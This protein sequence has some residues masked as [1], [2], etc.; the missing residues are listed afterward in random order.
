MKK[1]IYILSVIL[2]P[3]LVYFLRPETP[4]PFPPNK[5]VLICGASSGIGKEIALQLAESHTNL[6]IV[7]RSEEKLLQVK[8]EALKRGA[9]S[10]HILSYDFS[11]AAESGTVIDKVIK[12]FGT[13]DYLILNHAAMPFGAF[14]SFP[15]H[16]DHAF[17]DKMFK[18]NVLS[19][20]ELTVKALPHLEKS[21]GHVFVTSSIAG[22]V[23][24]T[25]GF[26]L[27]S[28]T[29]HALN[30]FFYSLQQEL[31]ARE[32]DVTLTLGALG[33]IWTDNMADMM[34]G[35]VVPYSVVS[36]SVEDCAAGIISCYKTRQATWTFPKPA[37]YLTRAMWYFLPTALYHDIIISQN[38]LPG[39]QGRGYRERVEDWNNKVDIAKR[40]CF[41]EGYYKK[42]DEP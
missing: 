10:V 27:Y 7:A 3:F 21:S 5:V 11:N 19:N 15:H 1:Y 13:L 17:I 30:G 2:I 28:S 29:K 8:E 37:N 12:E 31:V 41:Q 32:S 36:G 40:N 26:N 25:Y 20:I 22:E 39:S 24:L 33:P 14:L 4:S 38:K 34:E 9:K 18:I 6:V 42:I 16:Q 35:D 23:P